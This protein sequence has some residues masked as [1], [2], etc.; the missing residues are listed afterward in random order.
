M[1][2]GLIG[3]GNIGKF[4]LKAINNDGLLPGGRI[5]AIY[6]RREEVAAQLAEE[7]RTQP[8]YDVDELLKSDVEFST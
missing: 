2:L 8:Y 3:C 4:L 6:A 1:K 5:V 7:F